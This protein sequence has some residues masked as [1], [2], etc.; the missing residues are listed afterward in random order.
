MTDLSMDVGTLRPGDRVRHVISAV[1][2]SVVRWDD[3]AAEPGPVVED[4]EGRVY[5]GEPGVVWE[6]VR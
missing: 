1:E 2:G 5:F 4:D 6:R 3:D